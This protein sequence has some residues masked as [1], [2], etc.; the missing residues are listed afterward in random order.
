MVKDKE[1]KQ[2]K[3]RK[4]KP[5]RKVAYGV[6]KFK[7]L[8]G[9]EH[10]LTLRQKKFVESYLSFYGN[11][12][13][14]IFEAGYNPKS[15][16]VAA[17][18][19]YENLTKPYIMAY[20]NVKLLEYGYSDES[21]KRQHLFLLNQ[22]GNLNAKGKAIDMFYKKFGDY[23]PEKIKI[24]DSNEDITDDQIEREMIKR[25]LKR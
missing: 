24:V 17:A 3:T 16:R 8:D 2:K 22:F 12:V 19:A 25:G 4:T 6:F 23:A 11:G 18:M 20:V 21:V 1:T 7:A 5:K 10:K 14:A 15:A 9:K 13:K